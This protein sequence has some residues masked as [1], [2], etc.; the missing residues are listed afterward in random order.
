M[1]TN[2]H[3]SLSKLQICDFFTPTALDLLNSINVCVCVSRYPR[4]KFARFR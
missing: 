2:F 3:T 4:F 1:K